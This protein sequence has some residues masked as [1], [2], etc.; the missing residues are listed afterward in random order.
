MCYFSLQKT[1]TFSLLYRT[2][3]F[4]KFNMTGTTTSHNSNATPA[5]ATGP[6]SNANAKYSGTA[7]GGGTAPVVFKSRASATKKVKAPKPAA[8]FFY[9][10]ANGL[11][12]IEFTGWAE[13]RACD[14]VFINEE[15]GPANERAFMDTAALQ[16]GYKVNV[17]QNGTY[18]MAP[19]ANMYKRRL[20]AH[21]ATGT[22]NVLN[23]EDAC[24]AY[25]ENN[26]YVAFRDHLGLSDSSIPSFG[27]FE[28][29]EVAADVL[30][31]DHVLYTVRSFYN[32]VERMHLL[33]PSENRIYQF[34]RRGAL[35][36]KVF[37]MLKLRGDDIDDSD[38]IRFGAVAG[39]PNGQLQ[40]QTANAKPNG[41]V[42]IPARKA[43]AKPA[44]AESS[45]MTPPNNNN[46]NDLVP[47]AK[48]NDS[49]EQDPEIKEEPVHCTERD[50]RSGMLGINQDRLDDIK[51]SCDDMLERER[52][53]QAQDELLSNV[54]TQNENSNP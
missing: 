54:I 48:K 43:Q 45:M 7:S 50:H 46:A 39:V 25:M 29:V 42:T 22:D 49:T 32:R 34:F 52:E 51:E 3:F 6:S 37:N 15:T 13:K 41:N 33:A 36:I 53:N 9:V 47:T 38:R 40:E 19:P 18:S 24:R 16:Y 27:S 17:F 26:A 2:P 44:S 12:L 21:Y 35:P 5:K 4:F 20:V 14:I 28:Y 8:N 31:P 1:V 10:R 30:S 11:T 23:S